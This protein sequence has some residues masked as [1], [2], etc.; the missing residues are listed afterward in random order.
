MSPRTVLLLVVIALFGALSALAL[1]DVGYLGIIAPHLRSW[2]GAQVLVDLVIACALGCLWMI[3]D[4]RARGISPWPFVVATFFAGSFGILFY[5][6]VRE[7]R[8][9]TAQ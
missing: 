2:G 1:A 7:R 3:Q 6:V 4:A 9:P 5:L 8:A